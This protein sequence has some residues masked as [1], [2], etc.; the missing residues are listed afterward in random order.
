MEQSIH[1]VNPPLEGNNTPRVL[2]P[3]YFLIAAM[4]SSTAS[5]TSTST[6]ISSGVPSFTREESLSLGKVPKETDLVGNAS[7]ASGEKTLVQGLGVGLA[8]GK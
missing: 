4:A 3:L 8:L 6:S 7:A 1:D 2:D 5:M